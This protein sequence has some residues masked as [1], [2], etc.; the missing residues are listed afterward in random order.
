MQLAA[1]LPASTG[2]GIGAILTLSQDP[3]AANGGTACCN[4]QGTTCAKWAGAHMV[5]AGCIQYG[6]LEVEAAF[7]SA[8]QRRSRRATRSK[9]AGIA[10]PRDISAQLLTR[11]RLRLKTQC[12]RMPAHFTL[13][14]CPRA[15]ASAMRACAKA[16]TP[17]PASPLRFRARSATYIVNGATDPSWNEVDMG[18]INNMLGQLEVRRAAMRAKQRDK[19]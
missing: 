18:F 11:P 12:P 3:C 16:V 10:A 9:N 8:S 7:D 1:P 19:R 5:S 2:G 4:A 13:R 6:V 17:R 14:A 15:R